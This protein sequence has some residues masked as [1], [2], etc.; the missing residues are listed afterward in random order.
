LLDASKAPNRSEE[1]MLVR[2]VRAISSYGV[3]P[4]PL[5]TGAFWRMRSM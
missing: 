3:A 4:G 5:F 2:L 1:A